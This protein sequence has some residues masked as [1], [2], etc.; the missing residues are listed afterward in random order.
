MSFAFELYTLT[1]VSC[2]LY[3]GTTFSLRIFLPVIVLHRE[4]FDVELQTAILLQLSTHTRLARISA[5]LFRHT[6]SVL[7]H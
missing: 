7:L 6:H 1:A 3:L 2:N 5:L 4:S